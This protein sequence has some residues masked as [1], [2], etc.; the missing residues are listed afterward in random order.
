ML[1]LEILLSSIDGVVDRVGADYP[2][3]VV[4]PVKVGIEI[5]LLSTFKTCIIF[6]LKSVLA[7]LVI[8]F[9]EISL[10]LWIKSICPYLSKDIK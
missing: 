5:P 9:K 1:P 10:T 2:Y 3:R 7:R 4:G 8:N 6:I